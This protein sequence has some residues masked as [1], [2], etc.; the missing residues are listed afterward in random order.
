MNSEQTS[1]STSS[2]RSI[3]KSSSLIGGASI[4]NMLIGMVRIKFV[5]VLLGPTGVGLL[6]MYGQVTGLI[7]SM[8]GVWGL[9]VA[10]SVRWPKQLVVMTRIKLLAP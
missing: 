8:T 10:A 1:S 5:A 2:F 6:G 9:V 7:S 4:I 3:L